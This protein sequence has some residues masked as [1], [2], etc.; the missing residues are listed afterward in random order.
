MLSSKNN[1]NNTLISAG[2]QVEKQQKIGLTVAI[3][4]WDEQLESDVKLGHKDCT[5]KQGDWVDGTVVGMV[6][7]RIGS[8]GIGVANL[9]KPFSNRFLGLN[10]SA[11]SLPH[12]NDPRTVNESFWIDSFVTGPQQLASSGVRVYKA[13]KRGKDL[14]GDPSAL[15]RPARYVELVQGV[16]ATSTREINRQPKIREGLRGA[17]IIR[18]REDELPS[19]TQTGAQGKTPSPHSETPAGQASST[20]GS[21]P[22]ETTP[23]GKG[24]G[25]S[26]VADSATPL[27]KQHPHEGTTGEIAG[28]MHWSDIQSWH[29]GNR[30]L[31]FAD[32]ADELIEDGWKVVLE[33][34]ERRAGAAGL[35]L[36]RR[37][38]PIRC[39]K[40][41]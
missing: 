5:V 28:F 3:H 13:N 27:N 32:A 41:S 4:C 8:S 17:A 33:P 24:R 19:G 30:L 34:E 40:S 12:S 35:D 38:R 23:T 11:S 31:C 16:Y 36:G 29:R 1:I 2:I 21:T 18:A 10:G 9:D 37:V 22:K 7:E 39:Q 25:S 20:Q 15:T 26:S 6:T 14:F